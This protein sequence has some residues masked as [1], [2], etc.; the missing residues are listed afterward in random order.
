M[1]KSGK[2]IEYKE[3]LSLLQKL[4]NQKIILTGGCFDIFHYGH[5]T[6]LK[7]AKKLVGIIMIALEPDEF[8][9]KRKKRKPLHK[10]DQRA[11][12]LASLGIVDYVIKLPFLQSDDKYFSLV[13]LIKPQIIAVTEGDPQLKNKLNQAEIVGGKV[14]T[15]CKKVKNLSSTN[16]IKK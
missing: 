16:I 15:V 11:E 13:K 9:L 8:I 5:L 4:E 3:L 2:I 7:N 12:I 6:F 10:Q 14:I 1:I